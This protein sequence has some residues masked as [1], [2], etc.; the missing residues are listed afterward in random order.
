M[1]AAVRMQWLDYCDHSSISVPEN[2]PVMITISSAVYELSSLEYAGSFQNSNGECKSMAHQ[3][4][5]IRWCSN[6]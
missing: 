3:S 4:S 1:V 2:N 5:L 6:L